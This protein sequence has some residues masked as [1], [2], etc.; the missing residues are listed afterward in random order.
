MGF[1]LNPYD[2]CVANKMVNGHQLTVMWYVDDLKISH[3]DN[4]VVEDTIK[5]L[6]GHFG[7][8]TVTRGNQHTYVDMDIIFEHEAVKIHNIE[9]IKETIELFGE[10]VGPNAATPAKTHLFEQQDDG[11]QLSKAKH[12]VFHSCVAKLLY[13]AKRGR[14]DILPIVSYLTTRVTKPNTHDWGKLRR[15]LQYL[16]GTIE[17]RLTLAADSLSMLKT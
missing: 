9:Y 16:H 15:L 17:L 8:M 5:E 4:N 2:T 6:E 10:D 13:I 1:S 12:K 3:V 11:E 7:E 14:P